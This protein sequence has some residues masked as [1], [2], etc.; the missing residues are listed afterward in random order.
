MLRNT[1]NLFGTD[2]I[3]KF[4]LWDTPISDFCQKVDN[5]TAEAEKL[6]KDL[7]ELFPNVFLDRL[8]C[9]TKM[10]AK[11]KLQDNVTPVF[12]KKRN[13]P[14]ASMQKIV[15]TGQTRQYRNFDHSQ[16]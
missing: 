5:L 11:F 3:Q 4:E 16:Q 6:K 12:K 2:W 7:K 1:N 15:N 13:I 8:G 10:E 9:C 14:F